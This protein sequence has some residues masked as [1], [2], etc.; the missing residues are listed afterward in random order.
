MG[1]DPLALPP[2]RMRAMGL[3]VVEMLIAR[4][5]GLRDGPALRTDT[6]ASMR[7]RLAAEPSSGPRDFGELLRVLD[8][9]VLPFVGHLSASTPA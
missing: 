2:D 1:S 9:D 8:D 4:I 3:A 5:E 7:E 6:L